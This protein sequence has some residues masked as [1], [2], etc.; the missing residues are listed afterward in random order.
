[1]HDSEFGEV[2]QAYWNAGAAIT[3][4]ALERIAGVQGLA[5]EMF[6]GSTSRPAEAMH[7]GDRVEQRESG[8]GVVR[9]QGRQK[10]ISLAA[11][12]L[13]DCPIAHLRELNFRAKQSGQNTQCDQFAA[14]YFAC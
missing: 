4:I 8:Y 9:I 6:S 13:P 10:L 2:R 14:D 12:P 5:W 7:G 1:M 11:I 3:L